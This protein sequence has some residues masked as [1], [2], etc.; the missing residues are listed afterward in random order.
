MKF[1]V[2]YRVLF[3]LNGRKMIRKVPSSLFELYI[4]KINLEGGILVDAHPCD[5]VDV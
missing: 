3:I 2:I 5:V 4:E 1:Q